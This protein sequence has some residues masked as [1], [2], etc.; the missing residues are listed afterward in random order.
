MRS[1]LISA[2]FFAYG[3]G[4]IVLNLTT[5]WVRSASLL[6]LLSTIFVFL[7]IVPAFFS[8]TETPAFQFRM[9]KITEFINSVSFIAERNKIQDTSKFSF[10]KKIF[11]GTDLKFL[12]NKTVLV[13]VVE[14]D[15]RKV[16]ALDTVYEMIT[17]PKHLYTVV[18]M[19]M[20]SSLCYL[21]FYSM[22]T[23]V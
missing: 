8:F 16:G 11:H 13:K 19:S 10:Y 18:T 20:V 4:C 12:M 23:S 6:N 21:L 1:T 3:L 22:S 7:S 14:K 15:G 5:F 17:T 2:S 9:G